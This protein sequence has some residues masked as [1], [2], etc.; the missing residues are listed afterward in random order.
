MTSRVGD[1]MTEVVAGQRH[2]VRQ[3]V[4]TKAV[5]IE[6][7]SRTT[8][9]SIQGAGHCCVAKA[10][11]TRHVCYSRATRPTC[12]DSRCWRECTDLISCHLQ[13]AQARY[14]RVVISR[15]NTCRANLSRCWPMLQRRC[16]NGWSHH[17]PA[18]P[19][20]STTLSSN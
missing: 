4:P 3:G 1:A 11:I 17:S 20:N 18:R 16:G 8:L 5:M 9:S 6:G 19:T 10:L 13:C 12:C 7:V 14:L 15:P 2:S